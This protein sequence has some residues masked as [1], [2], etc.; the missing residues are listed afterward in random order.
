[1]HKLAQQCLAWGV[2]FIG[3]VRKCMGWNMDRDSPR[4]HITFWS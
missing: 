2:G 3:Y 4:V 1:M